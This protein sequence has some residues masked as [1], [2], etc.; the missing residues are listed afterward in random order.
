MK[1]PVT[2]KEFAKSPYTA[3]LFMALMAVGY[4]QYQNQ[5]ILLS[6]IQDLND[7]VERAEELAK[8]RQDQLIEHLQKAQFNEK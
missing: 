3:I 4:L 5:N 1:Q 7:K 8:E 2:F 6:T